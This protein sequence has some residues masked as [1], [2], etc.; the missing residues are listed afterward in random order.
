M[1]RPHADRERGT[2]GGGR[3]RHSDGH[4]HPLPLRL[5]ADIVVGGAAATAATVQAVCRL[6]SAVRRAPW[7]DGR[8]AQHP[9]ARVPAPAQRQQGQQQQQQQQ[10]QQHQGAHWKWR[11]VTVNNQGRVQCRA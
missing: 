2:A 9:R 1:S 10:Q 8:A 3:L 11:R 7:H 4:D 5:R 6:P